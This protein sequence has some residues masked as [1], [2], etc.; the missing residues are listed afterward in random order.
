MSRYSDLPMDFADATL[1]H[2]AGRE[3]IQHILTIEQ[4]DFSCLSDFRQA[5]LPHSSRRAAVTFPVL[6]SFPN[7]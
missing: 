2:L 6:S 1:V 5:A 3:S 7:E 4:T